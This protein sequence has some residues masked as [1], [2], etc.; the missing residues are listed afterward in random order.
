MCPYRWTVTIVLCMGSFLFPDD[1]AAQ[2]RGYRDIEGRTNNVA[3]PE[4][5]ATGSPYA[6]LQTKS[7]TVDIALTLSNASEYMNIPVP[8]N[9][10]QFDPTG[11]CNA[12]IPMA[13][14]QAVT[15]SSNTRHVLN[16]QTAYI[17]LSQVY[18]TTNEVALKLRAFRRGLLKT[19]AGN[20]LPQISPSGD[21]I[22]EQMREHNRRAR[23]LAQWYP[24]YDDETL[25]QMARRWNIALYQKIVYEEYLPVLLGGPLPPYGGYNPFANPS[26][27]TLFL[28]AAFRYGH[29][30][31]NS[32]IMRLDEK[33]E[34]IPNGHLLLRDVFFNPH[35][36][37]EDGIDP[38]FRGIVAQLESR[39][40]MAIV[41]DLR[42]FFFDQPF[43]LAAITLLIAHE[44]QLSPFFL[45]THLANTSLADRIYNEAVIS[46]SRHILKLGEAWVFPF[47]KDPKVYQR[48]EKAYDGD[49]NLV[50]AY[51]GGLAEPLLPGAGLGQLF[52]KS[53]VEQFTRLRDGDRFFYE[54]L[55]ALPA[56]ETEEI[57]TINL[58]K[59]MMLNT[60]ITQYPSMAFRYQRM[61]TGSAEPSNNGTSSPT[62]N[63]T[64]SPSGSLSWTQVVLTDRLRF[65]YMVSEPQQ[66]IELILESNSSGWTMTNADIFVVRD[67]GGGRIGLADM[68]SSSFAEP[69][70]DTSLNSKNSFVNV[71]EVTATTFSKSAFK[72]SRALDT[73]ESH[74]AVIKVGAN[75]VI[76][77]WGDSWTMAYHSGNRGSRS[78]RISAQPSMAV[79]GSN[80]GDDAGLIYDK[81]A[82]YS[83]IYLK[84]GI[85]LSLFVSIKHFSNLLT[86]TLTYL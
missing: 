77:A 35:P 74:D 50:D 68:W 44:T 15:D 66:S 24:S 83:W 78:V 86:F 75:D 67:V 18:G 41:D 59:L 80:Q 63:S 26:I 42:K 1:T 11:T 48:L 54:A 72:F 17:D 81:W 13:R 62:S 36:V 47:R 32:V 46:D 30:A 61:M 33:G 43:D 60:N 38:I 10:T 84:Y 12:S 55:G 34:Q 49:I 57:S 73:G 70:S 39:V 64:Q 22:V 65:S 82:S 85:V 69:L 14:A 31:I 5:G 79:G 56:N 3:N 27:D 52:Q 58:S 29:S 45:H 40:D 21:E 20:L 71:Q 4:W 28:G 53:L 2:L 7:T 37:L 16:F 25:Y 23:L 9:D 76:Y 51:I 8:C 19:S 6:R